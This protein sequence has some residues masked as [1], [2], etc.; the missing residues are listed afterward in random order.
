MPV[1]RAAGYPDYTYDGTNKW[2][3]I[4]FAGKTLEKFYADTVITNISTTDYVG[5]VRNVGDRVVIRTIPSI[6]IK[7]Y[8][9]GMTLDLEYPESPSIEFS[10]NKAKYYNFAMD[11]IDTHQTD[12]SWLDK[13]SDDASMQLKIKY[14]TEVFGDVYADVDTANQGD[15]AGKK[16]GD[17]DLGKAG[18]PV[19]VTKT[20]VIDKIVDCNTVLDEQDVPETDR[21]IVIPPKMSGLI[22]KSDLRDASLTGDAKSP[23]RS[24]LI[25]SIDRFDIYVSN[26]LTRDAGDSAY[27][28]LFGHKSAMVFVAQLT[29]NEAYRPQNTFA[30]AMKGLVVYDYDVLQPTALGHLYV[31]I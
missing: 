24:G 12:L 21:W 9:K 14:D 6:T 30:D 17:I 26:L 13:F 22:K 29:K 11:D 15:A 31:T 19:T 2:I 1:P 18:T 20:D 16:S 3:P 10:V 8:V 28:V 7:D 23:L 5:E 4:L 27:H 25:G